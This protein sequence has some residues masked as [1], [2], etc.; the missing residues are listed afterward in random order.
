MQSRLEEGYRRYAAAASTDARPAYIAPVGPAFQRIHDAIVASGGDP[1]EA[2]SCF[3]RLYSGDGSHPSADGTWVAGATI[4]GVITGTVPDSPGGDCGDGW[5]DAVQAAVAAELLVGEV[6]PRVVDRRS[7]TSVGIFR[8]PGVPMRP[9]SLL[10][11]LLLLT[12]PLLPGCYNTPFGEPPGNG[13]D[14][15]DADDDDDAADDDDGA[16]DDDAADDDDDDDTPSPDSDGDGISDADEGDGDTDGDGT[17]DAQDDDSDGDGIPDS[18]E[19]GDHDADTPPIDTDGDGTPDFQDTDSDGDTQSDA[20]EGTEDSDGDTVPDYL[21]TDSDNDLL[22]D[23]FEVLSGTDPTNPDSDGDGTNDLVEL[24]LGTDAN[25]P[26]DNPAN[27]GDIV[28]VA[29]SRGKT[30]PSINT[31]GATTNYQLVDLYVL[32]DHTG[33][34]GAEISSMKE[35]AVDIVDGL[36]CGGTGNACLENADCASDEVCS[37]EAT[38]IHD[39]VIYSCVPSLWS[40]SGEF[41]G[42]DE[43]PFEWLPYFPD[44]TVNNLSVQASAEATAD[45]IP[46]STGMGG[47]ER[48]FESAECIADPTACDPADIEGC[49]SGGVGCPSFRD[50]SV[51]VLIQITDEEDGCNTC[52]STAASAGTAM[53]VA[54]MSYIGINAEVESEGDPQGTLEAIALAAGSVDAAGLPFVRAG[55]DSDVV[56]EVSDAVLELIDDISMDTEVVLTDLPDDDGDGLPFIQR[57]EVHLAATDIDGDGTPDCEPTLTT[58]DLDGDGFDDGHLEVM[59]GIGVCWDVTPEQNDFMPEN[60]GIQVFVVEASMRG[61]GAVLGIANVWF[62]VPPFAPK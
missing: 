24:A 62:V 9:S 37:L 56:D 15:D 61:N 59:P 58:T 51:R 31:I 57:I 26:T 19:A 52:A 54:N 35:A 10:V 13:V 27:N 38:C 7:A 23:G 48:V 42:S 47:D 30:T 49:T 2:G 11:A 3:D 6:P 39:P 29:S 8:S 1:Q 44:P 45:S 32:M 22:S 18:E 12:W 33:S 25:D 53:Q 60:E 14:D 4:T 28:F 55:G 46:G 36:T 21:D 20:S 43:P 50:G 17:P 16:N 40:G 41:G 5:R 34:M